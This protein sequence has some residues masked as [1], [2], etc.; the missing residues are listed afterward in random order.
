M[1]AGRLAAADPFCHFVDDESSRDL[2]LGYAVAG[3]RLKQQL[4]DAGIL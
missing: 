4:K 2:F 3:L 1:A